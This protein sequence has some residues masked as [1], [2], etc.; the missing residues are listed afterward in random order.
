MTTPAVR[1]RGVTRSPRNEALERR[2]TGAWGPV[3][4]YDRLGSAMDMAHELAAEG[5]PEGS[6]V[7]AARQEQGRGRQGR[8]W[9]SPEGG[10]YFALIV[11]PLRSPGE[12]PQLSLVAGLACAEAVNAL[13]GLYP[14]IR[15]PND[16]L[17]EGRKLA[18]I[19]VEA[20]TGGVVVGIGVNVTTDPKDLP[21]QATSLATALSA[22]PEPRAQ[23][24]EPVQMT[25][26]VCRRFAARY[27]IWSAQGFAPFRDALRPWLGHFGQ[28]VHV[29]AGSDYFEGTAQDV[30]ERGRLVVRLD[31]GVQRT[32]EV[33]EVALLRSR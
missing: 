32:F 20:K 8:T 26:E 13:T 21:E 22:H 17:L 6:L 24:P 2:L 15:W 28:P 11:R 7:F 23:S 33:G 9:T 25:L 18:G 4:A 3:F 29:S 19:L 5:T 12:T 1:L 10:A 27:H 14:S 30:D 31:S 16:L